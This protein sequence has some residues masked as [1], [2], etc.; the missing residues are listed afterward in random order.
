[1]TLFDILDGDKNILVLSDKANETIYVWDKFC[2]LYCYE[3][4]HVDDLVK[5]DKNGWTL[6]A[7]KNISS[8]SADEDKRFNNARGHAL[9]WKKA[10]D[11]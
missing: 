2:T 8:T 9:D 5:T 11:E 3:Y 10:L 4:S 6:I 7:K 1:M